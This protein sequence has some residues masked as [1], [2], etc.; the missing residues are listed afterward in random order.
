VWGTGAGQMV[1]GEMGGNGSI[2]ALLRLDDEGAGNLGL[3]MRRQD[4]STA[5]WTG[6]RTIANHPLGMGLKLSTELEIAVPDKPNGRGIAWPW[7]L[8]ALS[9]RSPSGWEVAGATEAAS[10][11]EHR[12]ELNALVRLA[13]TMELR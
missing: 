13:R 1:G 11:P 3:E 8:M 4:V 10:T 5:K 12:F 7:G 6:V 9:W 2:R